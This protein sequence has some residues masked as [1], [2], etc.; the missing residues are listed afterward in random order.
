MAF[1]VPFLGAVVDFAGSGIASGFFTCCADNPT[2]AVPLHA[3]SVCYVSRVLFITYVC[4]SECAVA[5]LR[6]GS[7]RSSARNCWEQK[8]P[9]WS[10]SSDFNRPIGEALPNNI[11]LVPIT[12]R[13]ALS[14]PAVVVRDFVWDTQVC[15]FKKHVWSRKNRRQSPS[16][17]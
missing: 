3:F 8:L 4:K 11:P 14:V 9:Y 2:D 7:P 10:A 1:L 13:K 17:G 16:Q 12:L 5:T 6:L 15:I